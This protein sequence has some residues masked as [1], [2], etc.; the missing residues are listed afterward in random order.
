MKDLL[1]KLFTHYPSV[2]F[3]VDLMTNPSMK[4]FQADEL[5]LLFLE[6]DQHFNAILFIDQLIQLN[7]SNSNKDDEREKLQICSDILKKYSYLADEKVCLFFLNKKK[8]KFLVLLNLINLG[9]CS[10]IKRRGNSEF[11]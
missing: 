5:V 8:A 7:Q 10:S 1:L 6:F 2:K 3:A 4:C 9:I 11:K